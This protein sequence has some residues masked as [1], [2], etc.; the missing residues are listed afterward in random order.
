[1][2]ILFFGVG[3]F[4]LFTVMGGAERTG[5]IIMVLGFVLAFMSAAVGSMRK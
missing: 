2:S 5:M 1:M 4:G 3:I